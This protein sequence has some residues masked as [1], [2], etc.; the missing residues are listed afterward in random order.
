MF[1]FGGKK[2]DAIGKKAI[3]ISFEEGER[4]RTETIMFDIVNM[5]YP[6]LQEKMVLMTGYVVVKSPNVVAK[7]Y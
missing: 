7:S 3:T 5:D 6:S 4:V 1:Y 2:I